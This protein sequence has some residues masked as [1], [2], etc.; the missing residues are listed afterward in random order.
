M[1]PQELKAIRLVLEG[2]VRI[3]YRSG[4]VLAGDVE[5]DNGTYRVSIDPDGPHCDCKFGREHGGRHS[6]TV[7]L[8]LA[9]VYEEV[10]V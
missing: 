8:E 3:S 6:H 1:T 7:A 2:H 10:L 9:D 4:D 5:G